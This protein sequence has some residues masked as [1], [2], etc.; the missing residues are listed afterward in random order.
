MKNWIKNRIKIRRKQI[1]DPKVIVFPI[2]RRANQVE[3]YRENQKNFQ[4]MNELK[5]NDLIIKLTSRDETAILYKILFESGPEFN[6]YDD[7]GG[8]SPKSA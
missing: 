6:D 3:K 8:D 7:F 4:K 5:N 1:K 2:A